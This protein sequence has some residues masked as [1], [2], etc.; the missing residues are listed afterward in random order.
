MP[1]QTPGLPQIALLATANNTASRVKTLFL[2]MP[3]KGLPLVDY[4]EK[5][6]VKPLVD[7]SE[8][9]RRLGWLP[10]VTLRWS[11]YADQIQASFTEGVTMGP[12]GITVGPN[13]GNMASMAD[14]QALLSAAPGCLEINPNP[15]DPTVRTITGA[16][17]GVGTG[18]NPSF[19]LQQ[20]SNLTYVN[21]LG[22]WPVYTT[23]R[24]NLCKYSQD[25][26]NALWLKQ[27]GGTGSVPVVTGANAVA[28]DGTP[29]ACTVV[30]ATGANTTSSDQSMLDMVSLTVTNGLPYANS[31][32]IKGT[33]GAVILLRGC[34]GA[35][36][37]TFTL[38]GSWQRIFVAETAATPNFEIGLRQAVNG[39]INASLTVQLWG[40]Q[41]EQAS[42]PTDYIPTVA[43]AVT[44]TPSYWPAAGS[45][46]SPILNPVTSTIQIWRQ[47]WQGNQ[48]M[49]P[50]LRTNLAIYSQDLTQAA[51]TKTGSTIGTAI[52]APDGTTTA[53]KIQEDTSTGV[54]MAGESITCANGV[55]TLTAFVKSA[56]RTS[57]IVDMSDGST[58]AAGVL[59]NLSTGAVSASPNAVG[60]W[61]GISYAAVAAQN[62]FW[63]VTVTATR[64]AGTVTIGRVAAYNGAASYTGTAGSGIY[65]WGAQVETGS[66]STAYIPTTTVAVT[67]TDY[68]MGAQGSFTFSTN[69]LAGAVISASCSYQ[70]YLR[71]FCAQSWKVKPIGAN[72][73]GQAEG[74]EVTFRGGSVLA[75]RA[76]GAF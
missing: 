23:P 14:L 66:A 55:Y 35:T 74:V 10:E 71:G 69:P 32:W 31:V 46:F 59:V 25:F 60:S 17:V 56:E 4:I 75:A 1:Y 64:A 6:Q 22:T 62:G 9:N 19:Q 2:P 36:Y 54:H 11:V 39:T 61:V 47:D 18:A 51:W 5:G 24:T 76:L 29:T 48:L 28:P 26:T 33:L 52:L 37:T 15:A 44:V 30:F 45:P 42:V 57:A 12:W 20:A 8:A 43:S 27:A 34:A 3:N 72:P 13:N 68:V 50:A 53:Q 41:I 16:G 38:N 21:V 49:Y 40:A 67:V 58:G 70:D 65:A 73:L 7:G 63:R